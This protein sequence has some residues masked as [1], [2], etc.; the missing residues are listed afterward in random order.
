MSDKNFGF[1]NAADAALIELFAIRR[2]QDEI[3]RELKNRITDL[4]SRSDQL[5]LIPELKKIP[6]E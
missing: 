6:L 1:S 3:A 4:R 5:F 2:N